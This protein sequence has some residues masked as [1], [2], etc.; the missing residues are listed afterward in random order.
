MPATRA[1]IR[2]RR[3]AKQILATVIWVSLILVATVLFS[4]RLA[5]G[6]STEGGSAATAC[7]AG[8]VAMIL[9]LAA[10]LIYYAGQDAGTRRT[11]HFLTGVVSLVPPCTIAM[12]VFPF[13][14][15]AGVTYLTTLFL[16][17]ATWLIVTAES[18]LWQGRPSDRRAT[19]RRGS[20]A[21]SGPNVAG[22]S[23]RPLLG[24]A[25]Q[26]SNAPASVAG[27]AGIQTFPARHLNC[28]E[29]SD[30]PPLQWMTRSATPDGSERVEGSVQVHFAAGQNQAAIH[31]PF[32]PPLAEIPRIDCEVLDDGS[33]RLRVTDA[34]PYGARIEVKRG[35]P[36][37]DAATIEVGFVAVAIRRHQHAA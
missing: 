35:Q 2:P 6:F 20:T 10:H 31:L 32:V 9:S 5:G 37:R 8:T 28:C 7:L 16:L 17:A 21:P 30:P 24:E 15:I 18:A 34:R 36:V 27:F 14:S 26:L 22:E 4:R 19:W 3:D 1:T 29:F 12:T 11:A 33:A 25:R 13:G 23:K